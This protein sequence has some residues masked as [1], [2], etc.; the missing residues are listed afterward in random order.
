[1][2]SNNL[3]KPNVGVATIYLHTIIEVCSSYFLIYIH[4]HFLGVK[5][6]VGS[7]DHNNNCVGNI[8]PPSICYKTGR[9]S[10]WQ[11]NAF[12]VCK[13]NCFIPAYEH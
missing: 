13:Y 2:Q 6:T 9:D 7:L 10:N 12:L 5:F 3:S 1:M 4:S 11:C 8:P